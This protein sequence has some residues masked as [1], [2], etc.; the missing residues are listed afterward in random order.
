MKK[1]FTTARLL[2][3]LVSGATVLSFCGCA[4][5]SDESDNASVRP[6]NAPRN[7]EGGLPGGLMEGR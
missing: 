2:L 4:T 5:T 1:L 3:L 6:W 7:W